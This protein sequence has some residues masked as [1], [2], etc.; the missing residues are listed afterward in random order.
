[1]VFLIRGG[2]ACLIVRS[3]CEVV[4][5]GQLDR[6]PAHL[7]TVLRARDVTYGLFSAL[8]V[9]AFAFA[10]QLAPFPGIDPILKEDREAKEQVTA[11]IATRYAAVTENGKNT[12]PP[13]LELLEPIE[14]MITAEKKDLSKAKL[15]ENMFKLTEMERIKKHYG[16]WVPIYKWQGRR[17]EV[18]SETENVTT[19]TPYIEEAVQNTG[20]WDSS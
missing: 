1:M 19:S 14:I 5:V 6:W 17:E 13:I 3:F 7:D 11:L 16:D 15:R 8:M 12:A 18:S 10:M 2:V 20:L 9:S 4:I